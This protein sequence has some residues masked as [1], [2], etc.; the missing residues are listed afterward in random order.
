M[1]GN[2]EGKESLCY[3][4]G[5]VGTPTLSKL[6]NPFSFYVVLDSSIQLW[7]KRLAH[8]SFRFLN[9]LYPHLFIN[10]ES[11]F[12]DCEQCILAKQTKTSHP[13]HSYQPTKLFYLVRSDVWG[14]TKTPNL[15]NT[16]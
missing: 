9:I 16:H 4:N 13:I 12:F 14:P 1:I 7:H 10:K 6:H 3:V 11:E 15:I 5:A 2:A 8:P